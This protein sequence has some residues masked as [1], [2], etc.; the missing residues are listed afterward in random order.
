M[1]DMIARSERGAARAEYDRNVWIPC[2][3]VFPAEMPREAWATEYGRAFSAIPGKRRQD[4]KK[5]TLLADVLADLHSEIY[6]NLPAQLA[7]IHM[8]APTMSPLPLCMSTWQQGDERTAR[9]RALAM[10][11]VEGALEP[12]TVDE[13]HTDKLGEGIRV[14]HRRPGVTMLNY[15]FR[16]DDLA[17]DVRI[18]AGCP[19]S[20]RL[21][22]MLP[23]ADGLVHQT[24]VAAIS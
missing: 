23:D 21:R 2:P 10:A 16:V 1:D 18:F 13:F 15:A 14:V 17:T 11:D 4:R 24:W 9:L 5:A 22:R 8:P 12:P 19:D 20:E 3:P 7:F 6:R